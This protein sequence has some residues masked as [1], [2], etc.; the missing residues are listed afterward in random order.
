M[1]TILL[2]QGKYTLVDDEDFERMNQYKWCANN[3]NGYWYAV[4]NIRKANNKQKT[5]LMHRFIINASDSL[6]VDHRNHNGLDNRKCN[7]RTC[8]HT[9]NQRNRQP[10][11]KCTSKYKGVCWHKASN[12][13]MARI[14]LNRKPIYLGLF[15]NE[16]IAAKVYDAKATK[17]FGKF[18]YLN[19]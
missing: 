19:F 16:I 17:L 18:A 14:R 15:T 8:N 7:L 6:E 12:K 2:T 10:L 3:I 11:Q 1:A 4:R 5:Q 9:E 13:W